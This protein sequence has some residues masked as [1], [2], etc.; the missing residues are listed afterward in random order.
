MYHFAENYQLSQ[1]RSRDTSELKAYEQNA[2]ETTLNSS[3]CSV[4]SFPCKKKFQQAL[5]LLSHKHRKVKTNVSRRKHIF[6]HFPNPE[7][8]EVRSYG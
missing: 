4:M 1:V 2:C 6:A 8:F 7:I 3:L 5:L